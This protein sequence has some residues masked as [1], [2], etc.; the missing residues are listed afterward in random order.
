MGIWMTWGL[1]GGYAL[2]KILPKLPYLNRNYYIRRYQFTPLFIVAV[3]LTYHG[4]KLM[5]FQK[6][7]GIRELAKDP[8]NLYS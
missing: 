2:Y 8:T 7:K 5:A 4:Y 3:T 1:L 6:R